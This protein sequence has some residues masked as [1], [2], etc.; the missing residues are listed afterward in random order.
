[1]QKALIIQACTSDYE[2]IGSVSEGSVKKYVEYFPEYLYKKRIVPVRFSRPASW[3][4][5][6]W[7]QKLC[8]QYPDSVC[9]W[10]DSDAV[11]CKLERLPEHQEGKLFGFTEDYN[12]LNC[13]VF[14]VKLC[15]ELI[16]YLNKIWGYE[17]FIND[18]WWEQR[19][20]HEMYYETKEL[21]PVSF[22]H[23]QN[24]VN[25]FELAEYGRQ[26][27]ENGQISDKTIVAH[28]PALPDRLHFMLRYSL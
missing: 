25:S 7:L 20:I 4:K 6:S 2:S 12:G 10:I 28:F 1:M 13:G 14:S 8:R 17:E 23:D 16:P 11:F 24:I 21:E 22:L 26:P 5:I 3:F 9:W 18:S 27:T 15:E 19:A